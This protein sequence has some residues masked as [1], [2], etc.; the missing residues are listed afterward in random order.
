MSSSSAPKPSLTDFF[1]QTV[2]EFGGEA[3]G[4]GDFTIERGAE[5]IRKDRDGKRT[6]R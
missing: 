6:S 4:Q 2:E 1:Q 3:T 5:I